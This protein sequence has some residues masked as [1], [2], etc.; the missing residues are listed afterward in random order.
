MKKDKKTDKKKGNSLFT[1]KT[2]FMSGFAIL[3]V[4]LVIAMADMR[5][6]GRP[7]LSEMDDHFIRNGQEETGANNI[8]TSVVFDYRGFDTLGE[9]S[10]LFAAVLGIGV[11]LDWGKKKSARKNVQKEGMTKIVK[12]ITRIVFVLALVFGIYVVANGHLTPGGGFQGGA[13]IAT[14]SA[15][16][17][18]AFGFAGMREHKHGF[19]ALESIGLVL[20]IAL[21]FIGMKTVFF[22]NFLATP[23]PYGPNPGSLVSAG[24]IPLMNL[25]V[26]LEVLAALTVM[27]IFMSRAA[28]K[29]D[30]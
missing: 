22:D 3:T 5:A 6:F 15:M 24:V 13:I 7:S 8:V 14:C 20:F 4:I 16:L 9:A 25:A 11:L 21:A 1:R 28:E 30:T 29:E 17:M 2:L 18:V 19:S 26:G 27:L 10:V 12:T 23:T